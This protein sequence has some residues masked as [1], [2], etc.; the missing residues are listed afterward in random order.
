MW[1]ITKM[2]K[3]TNN[4][5]ITITQG[6]LPRSSWFTYTPWILMPSPIK[7]ENGDN[8]VFLFFISCGVNCLLLWGTMTR[9]EVWTSPLLHHIKGSAWSKIRLPPWAWWSWASVSKENLLLGQLLRPTGLPGASTAQKQLNYPNFNV[10]FSQPSQ[11]I[12]CHMKTFGWW[13]PFP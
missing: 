13:W 4:N 10:F 7:A 2:T 9:I 12:V 1:F 3:K 6:V 5:S 8:K 11:P